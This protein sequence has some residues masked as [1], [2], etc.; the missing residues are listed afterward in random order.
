MI[1]GDFK[2]IVRNLFILLCSILFAACAGIGEKIADTTE[3]KPTVQRPVPS[4]DAP[5]DSFKIVKAGRNDT[6][7]TLAQKYLKDPLLASTIKAYNRGRPVI[8]G[9]KLVIPFGQFDR[10]GLQS[11]GY[12]TVPVLLYHKFSKSRSDKMTINASNFENQMRYLAENG[13]NV[14]SI[15]KFVDFLDFSIQIPEKSVVITIDDGWRSFYDIGFPILIKYG[16]PATL[17]VYTDFIA[18]RKSISWDQ[19][20]EMA[21]QGINIECHTKAHRNMA[22]LKEGETLNQYLKDII[23][24]ISH[25]KELIFKKLAREP[26]YLAY[27][28]GATNNIVVEAAKQH[29]FRAAFTV[30]RGSNPF[31]VNNYRIN[32]S[33]IY[34][35]YGLSAFKKNLTVFH[36]RRLK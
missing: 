25:S 36:K 28:Y 23:K 4:I 14:I 35:N 22:K 2:K 6:Y 12:Q 17:F 32:R 33:V 7:T 8:F 30:H 15:D 27:P 13:Y 21:D 31:F 3:Q 26:Q 29:G 9:Q 34:G 16:F 19:A 24:E 5:Y 10:G 18:G 20:R 11:E 1:S